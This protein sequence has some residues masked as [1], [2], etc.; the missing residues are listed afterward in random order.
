MPETR[1]GRGL[2]HMVTNTERKSMKAKDYDRHKSATL[3][4]SSRWYS[5]S[6][7]IH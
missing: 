4:L 2:L 6:N 7:S 5:A 3:M 1:G